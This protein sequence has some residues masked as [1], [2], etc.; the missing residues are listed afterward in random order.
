MIDA[1]FVEPSSV[2]GRKPALTPNKKADS[3]N[4]TIC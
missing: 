2:K 3:L 4:E 1:A